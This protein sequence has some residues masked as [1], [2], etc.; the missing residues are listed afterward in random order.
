MTHI[1]NMLSTKDAAILLHVTIAT[2]WEKI[3]NGKLPARVTDKGE[4]RIRRRDVERYRSQRQYRK[5]L[6]EGKH[7]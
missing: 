5:D 1:N 6:K 2:V 7:A 3:L 4:Y